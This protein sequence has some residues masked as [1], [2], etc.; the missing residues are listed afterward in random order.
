[1]KGDIA[2]IKVMMMHPMENG[3]RKGADGKIVAPHFIQQISVEV[4]GK[5]VIQEQNG[6]A[7]S[8]NP[9]FTFK[10]K[11]VKAGEKVVLKWNDSNGESRTDETTIG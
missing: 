9:V 4:G 6:T 10:V 2:E 11:G 8:L 3:K 7:L 1:M 5:L